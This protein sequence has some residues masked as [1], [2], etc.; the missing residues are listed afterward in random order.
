MSKRATL[1]LVRH[2]DSEWNALNLLAGWVDV[3]LTEKGK[4]EAARAG[5]L[6]KEYGLRPDRLHTSVLR[7]AIATAHIMLDATDLHW[8]PVR[9][10]WRLNER[11]YGALQGRAKVEVR[12]KYGEEQCMKWW[13][14]RRGAQ[15]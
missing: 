12:E 15:R 5:E 1:V 13:A 10:S 9:R 3:G 7:R 14:G 2:G 6:V 11:H 4:T 8:I